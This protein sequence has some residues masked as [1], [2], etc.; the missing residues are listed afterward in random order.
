MHGVA[1]RLGVA[2]GG[3]HVLPAGTCR[4]FDPSARGHERGVRHRQP[5]S[6]KALRHVRLHL[7]LDAH[8]QLQPL[9]HAGQ[10]ATRLPF[11]VVGPSGRAGQ[12]L[13]AQRLRPRR[14]YQVGIPACAVRVAVQRRAV[15][16]R[17]LHQGEPV[18]RGL[19]G[20]DGA[21]VDGRVLVLLRYVVKVGVARG[22][23]EP[24]RL[25]RHGRRAQAVQA[26]FLEPPHKASHQGGRLHHRVALCA[27]HLVDDG[28]QD[29]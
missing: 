19:Q 12:A 4:A 25:V 7:R 21:A 9:Q 5:E 17:L 22:A 29:R 26:G 18:E 27:A 2:L 13:G 24:Q 10:A 15:A 20:P 11:A 1:A 23:H 28:A 14:L 6:C 8:R 3:R 16:E